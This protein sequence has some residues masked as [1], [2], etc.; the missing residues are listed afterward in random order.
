M[1]NYNL[2]YGIISLFVVTLFFACEPA[3][4]ENFELQSVVAVDDIEIEVNQDVQGGNLISLSVVT[5]GVTGYWNYNT[6]IAKSTDAEFVYPITGTHTFTFNGT[7]GGEL[8]AKTVDVNITQFSTPIADEYYHLAGSDPGL[9]KSWKFNG[10]PGNGKFWYMAPPDNPGLWAETWW[11]AGECCTPDAAGTMRFDLAGAQNHEVTGG[12]AISG[13]F[14]EL[15]LSARSLSFVDSYALGSSG[16]R[17]SANG[18]YHIISLTADEMI[19]YADRTVAGDSG[20]TYSYI[21]E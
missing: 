10:T 12:G 11:D 14:F 2:K 16:D 1:K 18:V 7:N 9:G 20:W 4:T 19:L 3:E 8:F 13:G 5:P 21:P 6:G 15:D 17:A